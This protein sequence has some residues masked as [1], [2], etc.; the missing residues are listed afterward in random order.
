MASNLPPPPTHFTVAPP[1]ELN[2]EEPQAKQAPP[3]PHYWVPGG[4]EKSEAAHPVAGSEVNESHGDTSGTQQSLPQ[5]EQDPQDTDANEWGTQPSLTRQSSFE[6]V[7]DGVPL[8]LKD[9]YVPPAEVQAPSGEDGH[10]QWQSEVGRDGWETPQGGTAN[11]W[12]TPHATASATATAAPARGEVLDDEWVPPPVT[13]EENG[14]ESHAGMLDDWYSPSPSQPPQMDHVTSFVDSP[15]NGLMQMQQHEEQHQHQQQQQHQLDGGEGQAERQEEE[16]PVCS[17]CIPFWEKK[18]RRLQQMMVMMENHFLQ[19]RQD[20]RERERARDVETEQLRNVV[21]ELQDR[22][23]MKEQVQEKKQDAQEHP[24]MQ[25]LKSLLGSMLDLIID[26]GEEVDSCQQDIKE[27]CKSME[28]LA[29]ECA[30]LLQ[31]R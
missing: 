1:R 9:E 12:E 3:A 18:S 29:A 22:L 21:K 15:G 24:Q 8:V 19:V 5:D 23:G 17:H 11:E 16:L 27:V 20:T 4:G 31:P 14:R 2:E 28:D 25:E 10:K 26:Q 30:A 6:P 7:V 13:A